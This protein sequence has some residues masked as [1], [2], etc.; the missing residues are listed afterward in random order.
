[1]QWPVAVVVAVANVGVV[2]FVVVFVVVPVVVSSS[3]SFLLLASSFNA[4]PCRFVPS[5][6]V[7][8]LPLALVVCIGILSRSMR[9]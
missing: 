8:L 9:F 1:M 3:L 4:A 2:G 6:V 7:L 5:S